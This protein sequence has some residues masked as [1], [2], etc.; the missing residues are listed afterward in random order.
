MLPVW[1]P[2][3]ALLRPRQLCL[4]YQAPCQ[5][6]ARST[7]PRCEQRLVMHRPLHKCFPRTRCATRLSSK[8]TCSELHQRT[9]IT[10][11]YN[12]YLTGG[13]GAATGEPLPV[14]SQAL[15]TPVLLSCVTRQSIKIVSHPH[16]GGAAPCA[17]Q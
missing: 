12:P 10:F 13:I 4:Y 5:C 7:T 17:V 2:Q 15:P 1:A 14:E 8:Q 6:Q 11:S 9:Q 3:G 16:L